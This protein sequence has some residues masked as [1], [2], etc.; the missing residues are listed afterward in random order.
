MGAP[1]PVMRR[2]RTVS[3]GTVVLYL[4]FFGFMTAGFLAESHLSSRI[5]DQA[6]ATCSLQQDSIGAILALGDIIGAAREQTNTSPAVKAAQ[7]D[8]ILRSKRLQKATGP[9]SAVER[10]LVAALGDIAVL[11]T[12]PQGQA[13]DSTKIIKAE[14]AYLTITKRIKQPR[15]CEKDFAATA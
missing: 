2:R 14:D 8:F 9:S 13:T 11:L 4:I 12:N 1:A 7:A 15:N 5:A 6:K 10:D 3:P